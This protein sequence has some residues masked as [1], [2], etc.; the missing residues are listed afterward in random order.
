MIKV[1]VAPLDTDEEQ[2]VFL[3]IIS[4]FDIRIS[5]VVSACS[6]FS[7]GHGPNLSIR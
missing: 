7:E 5:P 3:T 1:L 2:G 6:E 4:G